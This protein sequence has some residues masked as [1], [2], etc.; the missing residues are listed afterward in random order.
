MAVY[1][2]ILGN[3]RDSLSHLEDTPFDELDDDTE[4]MII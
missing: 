3:I 4:E 1:F 2:I